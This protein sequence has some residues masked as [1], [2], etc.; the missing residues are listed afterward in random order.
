MKSQVSF[1]VFG[2][3]I[4]LHVGED[5]EN[6]LSCMIVTD[7]VVMECSTLGQIAGLFSYEI[8]MFSIPCNGRRSPPR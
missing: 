6:A 7:G 8:S 3:P 4:A 1:G 5:V 2:K